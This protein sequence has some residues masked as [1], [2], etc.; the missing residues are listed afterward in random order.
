M[1]EILLVCGTGASSGF[2]AKNIRQAA[3]ARGLEWSVKAR[4]DSVIEDYIDQI[5]LLMVGPHLSYMLGDLEEVAKPY[6]VPVA[7][8]PKA[9]YGNLD[10]EAVC[11][12]MLPYLSE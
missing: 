1:K 3:K 4:S 7:I 10:G 9:D 8:I 11:D 5:D 6:G 12:F 2:M